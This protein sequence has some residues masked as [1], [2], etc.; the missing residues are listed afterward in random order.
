M[1]SNGRILLGDI[2]RTDAGS[3]ARNGKQMRGAAA[4]GACRGK[5]TKYKEAFT[6]PDSVDFYPLAHDS[7]G[8]TS[9]TLRTFVQIVA[10]RAATVTGGHPVDLQRA[11]WTVLARENAESVAWQYAV[12]NARTALVPPLTAAPRAPNLKALMMARVAR[13]APYIPCDRHGAADVAAA[14]HDM[15]TNMATTDQATSSS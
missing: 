4:E 9:R 5:L 1:G 11:L 15:L 6:E 12:A 7:L 8:G 10:T 14:G 13:R 2:T 3:G